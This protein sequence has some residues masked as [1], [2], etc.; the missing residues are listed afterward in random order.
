MPP[1]PLI[2]FE[3]QRYYQKK[4]RFNGVY[5]RN[6]LPEKIKGGVYVINLDEYQKKLWSKKLNKYIT[7]FDGIDTFLQQQEGFILFS[8]NFC[9][10]SCRN[11]EWWIYYCNFF[12]NRNNRKIIKHIKK[13]K[14]SMIKFLCWLKVSLIVDSL[15]SQELIDM[16]INEKEL[17]RFW[18]KNTVMRK[19][20]KIWGI[21]MGN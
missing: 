12:G 2:N 6:N 4:A 16:E 11:S 8:C 19:W 17:L 10:C 5:S 18:R 15:V 20:K 3:I 13:Q 7:S 9:W 14:K 21:W 1:H